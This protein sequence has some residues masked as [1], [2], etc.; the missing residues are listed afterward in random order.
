[1]C[2]LVY[3]F[4]CAFAFPVFLIPSLTVC[5][6]S[7]PFFLRAR[8]SSFPPFQNPQLSLT[9]SLPVLLPLSVMQTHSHLHPRSHPV[10]PPQ[11]CVVFSLCPPA[12][13]CAAATMPG[14][15]RWGHSPQ[16]SY[17]PDWTSTIPTT[18]QWTNSPVASPPPAHYIFNHSEDDIT[19][20]PM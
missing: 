18:I 5:V 17:R 6:F 11:S 3:L 13:L 1:M 19:S 7:F 10:H 4:A 9:F 14:A 2:C 20:V 8:W 12:W 15:R 16:E